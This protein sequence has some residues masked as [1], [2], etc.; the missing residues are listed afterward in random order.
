[1]LGVIG[2]SRVLGSRTHEVPRPSKWG[3]LILRPLEEPLEEMLEEEVEWG[4][5]IEPEEGS[6]TEE[7]SEDGLLR[8]LAVDPPA[9]KR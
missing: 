7:E 9:A 2:F 1:M 4:T 3:Y 6:D 5:D 8:D